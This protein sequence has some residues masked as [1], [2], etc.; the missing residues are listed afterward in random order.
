MTLSEH[1]MTVLQGTVSYSMICARSGRRILALMVVGTLVATA[2]ADSATPELVAVP[3]TP[4][5][6]PTPTPVVVA[7]P[8]PIATAEPT[9]TPTPTPVPVPA[10]SRGITDTTIA[11]GVIKT[12]SVFGDVEVGVRARLD[13]LNA[14]GGI[15]GRQI[16]MVQVI[17]DAGDPELLLAAARELVETQEVFAIV[18]ASAVP[19]PPVTDYLSESAVPFFGWGFSPGFCAPND[20]GF[21]FNGCLV[22]QALGVDDSTADTSARELTVAFLG[23]VESVMLIVSDDASGVVARAEAAEVWGEALVDV[24]I[25]SGDTELDEVSARVAQVAPDLVLLSVDLSLAIDLK[26]ALLGTFGGAVVDDVSY[27]P[28]LLGD[29]AIAEKLEGGLT[30]SQFPPQEEYRDVTAV[31]STDLE[32][33]GGALIYSQAVSLGY[34]STDLMAA[35]FA[36][37]GPDLDTAS[38]HERVNVVGVDYNPTVDGA[39]CPMD[40]LEI[41]RSPAG[42]AALVSVDG[43]IYFPAVAFTCF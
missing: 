9:A 5:P 4:T 30:I 23:E 19:E 27:L 43:G 35:L 15:D 42:G 17:D 33:V 28:G 25:V 21:G 7:S 36:A 6:V 12:G 22:G 3:S 18:L 38:F 2:C 37:V 1:D 11:I 8:T 29:F 31:M 34:W 40:T 10:L 41:H 14:E 39:P 32:G 16:E 13:R 20:W 24:A 26:G